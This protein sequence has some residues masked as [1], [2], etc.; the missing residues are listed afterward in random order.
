MFNTFI[1]GRTVGNIIRTRWIVKF[2]TESAIIL[3]DLFVFVFGVI[4]LAL[5]FMLI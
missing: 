2:G 3:D 5:F 1:I 4:L